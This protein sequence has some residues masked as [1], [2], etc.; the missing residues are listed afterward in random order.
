MQPKVGTIA[1]FDNIIKSAKE[2]KM[3]VVLELDPNHSS[4][5]HPWFVRSVKREDPYT[6]Y[7]V[8]ADEKSGLTSAQ[9]LPNNWVII[10][11]FRRGSDF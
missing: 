11:R 1:E 9:K 2:R 6:D 3:R 4:V 7:Y 8:W 5:E 10:N